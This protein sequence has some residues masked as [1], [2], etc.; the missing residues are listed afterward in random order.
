MTENIEDNKWSKSLY[1]SCIVYSA[2]LCMAVFFILGG[3]TAW[4][5]RLITNGETSIESHINKKERE[6]FKKMNKVS[7]FFF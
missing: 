6:R 2:L 1:H 4:H 3:L 5:A 7:N